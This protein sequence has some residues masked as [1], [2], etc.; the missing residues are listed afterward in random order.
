MVQTLFQSNVY[1]TALAMGLAFGLGGEDEVMR[2]IDSI[3]RSV[4]HEE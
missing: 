1:G 3:K 4:S 2:T